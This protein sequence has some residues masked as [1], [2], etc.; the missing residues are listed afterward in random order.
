MGSQL[1][2]IKR[3]ENKCWC[4]LLDNASIHKCDEFVARVASRG[5][6]VRFIPPY[7]HFLSTLDNGGFGALV[8]WLRGKTE[9][10]QS[11]GIEQGMEDAF[12]DLNSDGGRLARRCFRNCEYM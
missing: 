10:V 12:Y 1:D 7:C 9:Y 3:L 2:H 11:V 6:I 4:I 8:Q 5:G